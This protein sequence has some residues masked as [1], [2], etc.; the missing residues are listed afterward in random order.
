[1][2][3]KLILTVILLTAVT[4]FMSLG[5]AD[6]GG[7]RHEGDNGGYQHGG[8]NQGDH[9][10][11]QYYRGH[12]DFQHHGDRGF[13]YQG[14]YGEYGDIFVFTDRNGKE[15]DLYVQHLRKP[16]KWFKGF[17]LREGDSYDFAI[18]Q[19]KMYPRPEELKVGL[20]LNFKWGSVTMQKGNYYRMYT[21]PDLVN[22]RGELYF[23]GKN[24]Y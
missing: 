14:A 13:T 6:E 5:F 11:S 9:N 21:S 19:T 16:G 15:Y 20:R 8:D 1:M 23:R 24:R 18:A 7:N 12:G 17:P 10:W 3:T 2:K 22:I 4:F